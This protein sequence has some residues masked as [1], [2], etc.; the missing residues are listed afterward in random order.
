MY[1][2]ISTFILYVV[3]PD[4]YLNFKSTYVGEGWFKDGTEIHPVTL[5]GYKQLV[6]H[7]TLQSAAHAFS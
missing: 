5:D 2:N 3:F 6:A 4:E 7:I 1:I